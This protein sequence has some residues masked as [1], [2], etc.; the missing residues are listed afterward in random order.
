[1]KREGC[2]VA[3]RGRLMLLPCWRVVLSC[4]RDAVE[5]LGVEQ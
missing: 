2:C 5:E 3:G 4:G 1:V